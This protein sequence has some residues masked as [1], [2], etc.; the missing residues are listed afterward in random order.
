MLAES[1]VLRYSPKKLN[2]LTFLQ[3]FEFDCIPMTSNSR[4]S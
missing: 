1:G 2:L 4:P 3:D